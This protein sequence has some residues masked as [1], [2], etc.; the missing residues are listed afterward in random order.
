MSQF[1]QTDFPLHPRSHGLAIGPRLLT[2]TLNRLSEK[3]LAGKLSIELPDGRRVRA[4][5]PVSGPD[6]AIKINRY[7]IARHILF[8][9]ALGLAD[10]YVAGDWESDDLTAVIELGAKNLDALSDHFTPLGAARM[11]GRLHLRLRANTRRGSRRNIAAHYDLGNEFYAAWLDPSMTYSSACFETGHDSEGDTVDAAV[12]A[13]QVRKF[14]RLAEML[15]LQPGDHM[16]E[17]GCGWGAFAIHAA[18]HYGCRVTALTVSPSQAAWARRKVNDAGL[19]DRI[20]I[21]LQDYRDVTGTFDKIASIEMFEAV[22]EAY[23]PTFFDVVGARLRPGG[24]AGMQV[25]TIDES[26]FEA[27]R[28]N[29]DFIQLRVFPGGMLPSP[30]RFVQEIFNAGLEVSDSRTFGQDYAETLRRWRLS[31]EAAWPTIAAQGFDKTFRRLWRY[32]LCYCEA[33]FR[34]GNISVAQYRITSPA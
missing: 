15:G 9:G 16:L 19:E 29:P 28:R 7:R 14:D 34:A 6:A 25:I 8:D 23:W 4:T 17:I 12:T 10:S 26:R 27:Y 11:L 31:F 30:T 3:L 1:A 21:R 20:E 22:G 2:S 13:A 24:I 32:Y 5:G 33:G 18:T